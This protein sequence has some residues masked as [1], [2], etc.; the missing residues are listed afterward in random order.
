MR[1]N[2]EAMFAGLPDIQAEISRSVDDGACTWSE[3]RWSGTR[4]DGQPFAMSGVTIVRIEAEQI[5]AGR[6]YMEELEREVVG[7][8]QAVESL[9]GERRSTARP[10]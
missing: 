1:A 10:N 3:W 8:E 5:V 9:S 6:L 7:I 4:P 2:W